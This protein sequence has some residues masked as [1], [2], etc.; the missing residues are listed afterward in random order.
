MPR[1]VC[2]H[3]FLTSSEDTFS[4][5]QE[6]FTYREY[7]YSD[8]VRLERSNAGVDGHNVCVARDHTNKYT[9][10]C[11]VG[12]SRDALHIVDKPQMVI[13]FGLVELEVFSEGF[14]FVCSWE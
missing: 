13:W 6:G 2:R 4:S 1:R 8:R 10:M 3:R 11:G 14:R 5:K 9:H 12:R 7:L